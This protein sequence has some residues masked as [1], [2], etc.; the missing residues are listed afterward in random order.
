[1][2]AVQ[3]L[4]LFA[5]GVALALGAG[6]GV[7]RVV[8]PLAEEDEAPPSVDVHDQHGGWHG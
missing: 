3:R 8:G 2:S 6:F 7:G 5:V 1:M 4:A